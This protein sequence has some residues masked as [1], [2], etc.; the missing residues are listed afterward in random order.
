MRKGILISSLLATLAMASTAAAGLTADENQYQGDA[1]TWSI[2]NDGSAARTGDVDVYPSKWS[3]APGERLSLKIRSTTGYTAK[4]F[5]LGWYGGGGARPVAEQ[6]GS[7]DPQPYPATDTEDYKKYGLLHAGWRD[8]VSFDTSSWVPGWYWVRVD[9]AGGKQAAT[10][11]VVRERAGEKLPILV[12][13]PLNTE[14]AYN[15]WPGKERGGKSIYAFNSSPVWPTENIGM[16]QAVK[17]SMD[18]PF[19]VGAGTGDFTNYQLPAVRWLEKEAIGDVA[20]AMD[21]DVDADPSILLGRKAIV[22]V[23][24]SEYWT[25]KAYDGAIAARNAGVNIMSMSGDTINWQVRHEDGYKTLVGYKESADNSCPR[26]ID[27]CARKAADGSCAV[28]LG[29]CVE[30]YFKSQTKDPEAVLGHELL[31]EGKIEEA[32]KHFELVTSH[33]NT[34]FA[35]SKVGLDVR[36]PGL[37]LTGVQTAGIIIRPDGWGF[38]W[39][40]MKLSTARK[41]F[42]FEGV[43]CDTIP[44]VGGYEI[45]SAATLD[46]YYDPWRPTAGKDGVEVGQR[47]WAGLVQAWDGAVRGST[48]YYRMQNGAEVISMS[49]MGF[50]WA[51]DNYAGRVNGT[52]NTES[53]CAKQLTRNALVRW[54]SGSAPAPSFPD[55]GVGDDADPIEQPITEAGPTEPGT[56]GEDAT[57]SQPSP[58]GAGPTNTEE[59]SSSSCGCQIPGSESDA[60]AAAI[61]AAALGLVLATRARRRR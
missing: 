21:T 1:A 51:L 11:F 38:P 26:D 60:R 61:A 14:H 7:A 8:S 27:G 37:Y 9:Q 46:R 56:P 30:D 47:R 19:L 54:M 20:Y 6:S 57:V 32:K 58:I 5:R 49:A 39:C 3:I 52:P 45:D 18:R 55:A 12:L 33:W 22:I 31:K 2:T 15:A 28:P 35:N 34:L 17:V 13:L 25:R 29:E 10:L 4:V 43:T 50:S 16:A 23:G 41:W 40:D 36:R 44:G 48:S 42:L 24:H 53:D 59:A